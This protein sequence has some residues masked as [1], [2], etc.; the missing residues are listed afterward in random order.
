MRRNDGF[1]LVETLLAI[2][3]LG[4]G[5]AGL[6]QGI[7][8]ALR[9]S[10]E[11]ELQT[12]AALFAAGQIETIRAESFILEGETEGDCGPGLAN[13][14]WRQTIT[15]GSIEGLYDV[16]VVVHESDTGQGVFTLRTLL[17]DTPLSSDEDQTT[18]RRDRDGARPPR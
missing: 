7:T 12:K 2:L 17:F 6:T 13:Y 10:K 16:E 4:T 14:G 9:A 15:P 8:A 11:S 1:S 18:R 3:I 5:L